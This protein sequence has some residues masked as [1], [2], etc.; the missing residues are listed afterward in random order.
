MRRSS[1][2]VGG[3]SGGSILFRCA[4]IGILDQPHARDGA[5]QTIAEAGLRERCQ[6]V[7]GDFFA[8]VPEDADTYILTRILHN[9]DDATS[10]V[11]LRSCRRAMPPEGRLLVIED[12]LP[13]DGELTRQAV[14]D[15]ISMLAML[16][17][18]ERDADEYRALFAQT[19]FRLS[20][21]VPTREAFSIVE[22]LPI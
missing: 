9:W 21:I 16:G 20:R 14:L 17:S 15:D 11:I 5:L 10:V 7:A 6:F 4:Q 3:V 2:A 8:A 18:R 22:A 1:A 12:V 13:S 19:A